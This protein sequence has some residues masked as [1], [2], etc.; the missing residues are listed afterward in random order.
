[1]SLLP[2]PLYHLENYKETPFGRTCYANL[3]FKGGS[4][5]NK[6]AV[7]VRCAE[8]EQKAYSSAASP[9]EEQHVFAVNQR[10]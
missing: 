7:H 8:S 4:S 3:D 2:F 6:N 9:F 1:M 5:R 10:E